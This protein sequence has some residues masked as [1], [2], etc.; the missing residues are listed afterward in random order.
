MPNHSVIDL[1]TLGT[2]ETTSIHNDRE[3]TARKQTLPSTIVNFSD[4]RG[5]KRQPLARALAGAT[6]LVA[7]PAEATR[8]E[9]MCAVSCGSLV[10]K[11]R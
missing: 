6:A 9:G 11:S 8:V 7:L 1:A 3:A 4:V 5:Q 2:P 10:L